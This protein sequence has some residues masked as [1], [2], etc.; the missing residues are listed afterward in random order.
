MESPELPISAL[1][2]TISNGLQ[3]QLS[4]Q[5]QQ[6]H[7]TGMNNYHQQVRGLQSTISAAINTNAT[8]NNFMN[9]LIQELNTMKLNHNSSLDLL[10][11]SNS[12]SNINNNNCNIKQTIWG[13]SYSQLSGNNATNSTL[14]Q[15][16]QHPQNHPTN[17]WG[18]SPQSPPSSSSSIRTQ[19][20]SASSHSNS[21][22]SLWTSNQSSP[23]SNFRENFYSTKTSSNNSLSSQITP[24]LWENP[25]TKMSQAS[26]MTN[27]NSSN[28]VNVIRK[29]SI[30]SIWSAPP[31]QPVAQISTSP[32]STALQNIA[33]VANIPS[34]YNSN[35]SNTKI[36]NIW[37]INNQ[38]GAKTNDLVNGRNQ[39]IQQQLIRPHDI[40][41]DLWNNSNN[42]NNINNDSIVGGSG[43][44]TQKSKEPVSSL[45]TPIPQSTYNGNNNINSNDN[46]ISSNNNNNNNSN[47]IN[48]IITSTPI[49]A[50]NSSI[51]PTIMGALQSSHIASITS[52]SSSLSSPLSTTSTTI[53]TCSTTSSSSLLSSSTTSADISLN[54]TT[55]SSSSMN[56]DSNVF[57]YRPENNN[58]TSPTTSRIQLFSDDFLNYLNMI[59]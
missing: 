23:N 42:D 19:Y 10:G 54:T 33:S 39:L 43:V 12:I 13:K 40:F 59:N 14:I 11:D 20:H 48:K 9:T 30:G 55:S 16:N 8:D 53:T 21:K 51:N 58:Q 6:Q 56:D 47:V 36:N 28:T 38:A 35:A 5:K 49:K 27:N 45:W 15:Q 24:N 26:L 32:P 34:A 37:D 22:E 3:H 25:V 7:I 57:L 17:I 46:S 29:D 50:N 31:V 41:S 44:Q 18:C 1:S 52:T 2:Q 4:H